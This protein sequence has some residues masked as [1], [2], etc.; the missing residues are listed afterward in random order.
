MMKSQAS[1]RFVHC[2]IVFS[3]RNDALGASLL[4]SLGVSSL[5]LR[6]PSRVAFFLGARPAPGHH[7]AGAFAAGALAAESG[8]ATSSSALPS[9]ATP[10]IHWMSP[11]AII[12]AEPAR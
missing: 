2:T 10:Q 5:D 11:A 1:C 8:V 7:P 12:T 9:L 4:P 6:P 3:L